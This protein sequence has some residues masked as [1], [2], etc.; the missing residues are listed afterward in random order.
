MLPLSNREHPKYPDR[1]RFYDYDSSYNVL[2]FMGNLDVQ[3]V[4]KNACSTLKH[5]WVIL[6]CADSN[7]DEENFG[8]DDRRKLSELLRSKG[9]LEEGSLYRRNSEKI[10]IYRD[11][12]KRAISSAIYILHQRFHYNHHKLT[13]ELINDFLLQF[14]YSKDIHMSKQTYW[15]GNDK[16]FFDKIY[17]I[18]ETNKAL[19]YI[20]SKYDDYFREINNIHRNKSRTIFTEDDL[21]PEVIDKIRTEYKDDYDFIEPF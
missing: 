20:R 17:R 4:P 2:H 1:N 19:D 12:M 18:N 8:R 9:S 3:V 13:K 6:H 10:A 16:Y 5:A 21:K 11:P 14:E 7:R 15:L